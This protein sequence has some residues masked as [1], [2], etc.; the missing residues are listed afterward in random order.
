MQQHQVLGEICPKRAT[1]IIENTEHALLVTG[2][3]ILIISYCFCINMCTRDLVMIMLNEC[4][5]S[6]IY[7]PRISD[8]SCFPVF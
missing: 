3:C 4:L 2:E 8:H 5:T 7:S 6:F 1:G